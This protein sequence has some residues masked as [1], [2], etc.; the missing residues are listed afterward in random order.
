MSYPQYYFHP[1]FSRT[2]HVAEWNWKKAYECEI[3]PNSGG[4]YRVS[5]TCDSDV[6]ER[7]EP[8]KIYQYQGILPKMNDH[9]IAYYRDDKHMYYGYIRGENNSEW[10]IVFV[11]ND[12]AWVKKWHVLKVVPI[13]N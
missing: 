7:A 12:T 13:N 1:K 6:I 9:V 2:T 11:D 4:S 3:S 10:Y 5:F 8:S